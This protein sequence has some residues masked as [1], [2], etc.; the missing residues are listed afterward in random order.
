MA[1]LL[2]RTV[3]GENALRYMRG[4]VV[5]VF[6]NNHVFGR[7]ESLQVWIAE[8]RNPADWPGGFAV[9]EIAGLGVATAQTYLDDI[10]LIGAARPE[11]AK[12]RKYMLDIDA[13]ERRLSQSDRDT[14]RTQ[15]YLK[16]TISD[17]D[18]QAAFKLKA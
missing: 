11:M 7:M 6:P 1:K 16:R 9:V 4:D 3:D 10:Q 12:R 13:I 14:L 17:A 18:V 2:V 8:G 15:A 5:G